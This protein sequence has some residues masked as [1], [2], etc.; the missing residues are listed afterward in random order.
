MTHPAPTIG[1]VGV[2]AMGGAFAAGLAPHAAVT[3]EDVIHWGTRGGEDPD[4]RWEGVDAA[5][6]Y[7][8]I[9][10]AP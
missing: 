7:D 3:V 10:E 2:G 1:V 5:P 6:D 9:D 8:G 4:A